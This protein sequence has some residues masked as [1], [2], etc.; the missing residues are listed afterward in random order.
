MLALQA[1]E[2]EFDPQYPC[3]E[4]G[5]LLS[6]LV[7]GV[8]TRG[9]LGLNG[10]TASLTRRAQAPGRYSCFKKQGAGAWLL[11]NDIPGCLPAFTHTHAHLY[12][13]TMHTAHKCVPL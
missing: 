6:I 3:Q 11:R 2:P 1:G 8:E 10:Q 12:T 13:H 9:S 4:V 7:L 5:S